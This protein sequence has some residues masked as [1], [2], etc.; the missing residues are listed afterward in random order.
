MSSGD[1]DSMNGGRRTSPSERLKR[2]EEKRPEPKRTEQLYIEADQILERTASLVNRLSNVLDKLQGPTPK[3]NEIGAPMPEVR[4][5]LDA[6][7]EKQNYTT[8]H[9]DDAHLLISRL[10]DLI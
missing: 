6:M 2:T 3:E 4:G 5:W 1:I 9:L 7:A 8:R 10:E